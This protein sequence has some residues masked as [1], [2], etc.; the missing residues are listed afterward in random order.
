MENALMVIMVGVGLLEITSPGMK[1]DRKLANNFYLAVFK[2][3]QQAPDIIN[4][5]LDAPGDYPSIAGF[6]MVLQRKNNAVQG[7]RINGSGVHLGRCTCSL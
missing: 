2:G 1:G 7:S 6:K 3:I 5:L 4:G